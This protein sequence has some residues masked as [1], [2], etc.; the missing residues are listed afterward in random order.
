MI[1]KYIRPNNLMG[2]TLDIHKISGVRTLRLRPCIFLSQDVAVTVFCNDRFAWEN[3]VYAWEYL[4]ERFGNDIFPY[5]KQYIRALF[6]NLTFG[7]L[8]SQ[9]V[10]IFVPETIIWIF[11]NAYIMAISKGAIVVDDADEVILA[12]DVD[13]RNELVILHVV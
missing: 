1:R 7:Y 10:I 12:R 13:A 2:F 9:L 6:C 4:R 3:L 11:A 5:V 8:D